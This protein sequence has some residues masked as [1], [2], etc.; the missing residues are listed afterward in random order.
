MFFFLSLRLYFVLLGLDQTS[1]ENIIPNPGFEQF[2][3]SPVGWYLKGE[4]FSKA[5]KYWHSPTAASPDAYGPKVQVPVSWREKGFG[6]QTPHTGSGMIGLTLYGCKY[7][8]PHCREYAQIQMAEPIIAGQKYTVSFWMSSL[9]NTLEINQIGIA[10]T[11]KPAKE[12]GEG[13]LNLHPQIVSKEI[14]KCRE[15]TWRQY[16][17]TFV[18]DA[19]YD[20]AILGN[21]STDEQTLTEPKGDGRLLFAY[22]Y[23]DDISVRKAPPIKEIA[24][25]DDDLSR[26]IPKQGQVIVLK[27]IFFD[28]DQ[29]E[30][31]PRSLVELKKL[32]ALM[33]HFP[34]MR[35]EVWGHTDATG[36]QEYNSR[37]SSYRAKAVVNFLF[38]QGIDSQRINYAGWGS[39]K[40]VASNETQE[41]RMQNRRVEFKIVHE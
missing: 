9:D 4:H 32:L 1:Q 41:G 24:I 2:S 37:L 13:V 6:I 36:S 26:L 19:S 5:I 40:P 11:H 31:M 12:P 7:G 27:D 25:P 30:L 8:K 33:Q 35:I 20:Y 10:F 17:T 3:R 39:S 22:Y 38:E 34:E 14:Q 28:W 18:A 29:A 23:F 16:E 15:G 21:F